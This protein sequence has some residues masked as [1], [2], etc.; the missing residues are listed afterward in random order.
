MDLTGQA[1]AAIL[2]P[3]QKIMARAWLEMLFLAILHYKKHGRPAQA[4]IRP[5]P[6]PKNEARRCPWDG[7]G[8]DFFGPKNL[9]FFGPA[10]ARPGP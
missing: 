1:W 6:N 3:A 9:G 5:E 4:W 2:Q 7:R 10:R 8:Q